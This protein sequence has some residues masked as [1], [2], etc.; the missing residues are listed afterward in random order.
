MVA[1]WLNPGFADPSPRIRGGLVRAAAL[2]PVGTVGKPWSVLAPKGEE[3][4]RVV[5][6]ALGGWFSTR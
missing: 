1:S 6:F 3:R 4:R 5:P 2:K